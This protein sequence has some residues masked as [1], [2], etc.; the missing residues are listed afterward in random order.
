MKYVGPEEKTLKHV[1]RPI[2]RPVVSAQVAPI[3]AFD[4]GG[5]TGW[6]LLLL[7]YSALPLLSQ[8]KC[9]ENKLGW[10]HG[11]IDCLGG[12]RMQGLQQLKLLCDRWPGAAV[13][14]E[15]FFL[16]KTSRGVD[17]S[18]VEIIAVLE[19][20]LYYQGRSMHMQQASQAKTTAT[21]E[22]LKLWGAYTS[23]GGLGH[24]RDADRHALLFMRRCIG[25]Q[26]D[27]LRALAWPH[28]YGNIS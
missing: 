5:T 15:S 21:D 9:L 23:E 12:N 19:E 18:P 16:R 10:W 13:V 2:L 17:L 25:G 14:C 20:Y 8:P 24:A 27:S 22:R 6:S 4:P 7:P 28:I 1:V 3:L 11:Q 26:G